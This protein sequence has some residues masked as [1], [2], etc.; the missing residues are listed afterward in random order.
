LTRP[1]YKVEIWEPGGGSALHSITSE[2]ILVASKEAL[3]D[4]VGSFTVVLPLQVSGAWKYYNVDLHDIVKIWYGY[5]TISGNPNFVGRVTDISAPIDSGDPSVG[6][7]RRITGLGNGEVLLR[8]LKTN[9]IWLA[10][11]VSTIASD[12]IDDLPPLTKDIDPTTDPPLTMNYEVDSKT[13]FDILREIS[14]YW[15]DASNQVK[16]D[17][18]VNWNNVFKWKSRPVRTGGVESFD[19]TSNV[20]SYKVLRNI[21]SVFN[22]IKVY[23]RY[24]TIAVPG[25]N[26]RTEPSN[27][28]AWTYNNGWIADYGTYEPDTV[29]KMVGADSLKAKSD[30]WGVVDVQH[31]S[32]I[33]YNLANLVSGYGKAKYL[34]LN[35]YYRKTTS[36]ATRQLRLYA[37]DASNYFYL[38]LA[39]AAAWAWQSYQLGENQ[40]YDATKNPSGVWYK[41]V[42]G[43]PNWAALSWLAFYFENPAGVGSQWFDYGID[44]LYFGHGRFRSTV[45]N[46]ASINTYGQR[47][48]EV[49]DERLSSDSDCQKRGETMLYQSKDPA[50]QV[51]MTVPGN[52][53]VLIGDRLSLTIPCENISSTSFDVLF[54]QHALGNKQFLTTFTGVNSVNVRHSVEESTFQMISDLRRA[55]REIAADKLKSKL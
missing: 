40:E 8:Q 21:S 32:L 41:N 29:S 28:D 50:V 12:L 16:R 52:T 3:S 37:P 45:S 19:V 24:G 53:N 26:G 46:S 11:A 5:D 43:S 4:N 2:A 17:F 48:L 7:T 49:V 47:D 33:R 34:T 44:G 55:M 36:V 31:R 38:T 30:N 42:G 23:G 39:D 27:M 51:E 14:D 9:K 13:Y 6:Y 15:V 10:T 54:V 20:K 18:W 25:D 35:F 22:N 1:V